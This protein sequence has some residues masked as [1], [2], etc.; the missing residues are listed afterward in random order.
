[1]NKALK[2]KKNVEKLKERELRRQETNCC[3]EVRQNI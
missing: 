1:M 2:T 3:I